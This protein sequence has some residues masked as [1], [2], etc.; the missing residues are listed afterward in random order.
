MVS[1]TDDRDFRRGAR[2]IV[3]AFAV[4]PLER[5]SCCSVSCG[6]EEVFAFG[7]GEAV[8]DAADG[9]PETIDRS[10]GGFTQESLDLGE[11]VLDWIEVGTVGRQ[12]EHARARV[13]RSS[14]APVAPCGWTDC[15]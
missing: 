13:P 8:D 14:A 1:I 2:L 11:G 15:P 10:F 5:R 9:A 6:G 4:R 3:A 7:L 12:V